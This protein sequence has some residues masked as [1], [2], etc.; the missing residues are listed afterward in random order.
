MQGYFEDTDYLKTSAC[1]KHAIDYSM[2]NSDGYTRDT[3]N[4]IVSDYDQND[5]YLVAFKYCI[6]AGN[7]SSIMCSYNEENGIPSCTNGAMM[8]DLLRNTYGFEG[9]I[10]SDCAAV[11]DLVNTHKYASSYEEA[12]GMTLNATM[13]IN[14][15]Q[16][17]QQHTVNA[18]NQ[19]YVNLSAVQFAVYHTS[20]T[21]IRLGM[22]DDNS[23]N[24]WSK[25]GPSDVCTNKSLELALNA[26]RKSMVL[27]KNKNSTLPI[28]AATIKS[29]GIAGPNANNRDVQKGNYYG[30]APFIITAQQGFNMFL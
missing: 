2:E 30:I 24:P 7:V 18:V 5:T 21:Q 26:T 15:G 1:C 6:E 11:W 3:F 28:D 20:L 13:D 27:L 19:G 22:F 9:Y 23:A 29:C 16:V 4:A 17:L 12:V 14:C 8:N 10:T 25:L